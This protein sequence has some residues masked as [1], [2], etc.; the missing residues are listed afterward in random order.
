MQNAKNTFGK[1]KHINMTAVSHSSFLHYRVYN[2]LTCCEEKQY[3]FRN[4]VVTRKWPQLYT[5]LKVV[6]KRN[7]P[8]E[9]REDAIVDW[10]PDWKGIR[11]S[12]CGILPLQLLRYQRASTTVTIV[13]DSKMFCSISVL[14]LP[15]LLQN[16]TLTKTVFC[17]ETPYNLVQ[18]YQSLRGTWWLRL[19]KYA[20]LHGVASQKTVR[21]VATVIKTSSTNHYD[22]KLNGIGKAHR[23]IIELEHIKLKTGDAC[24]S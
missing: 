11:N 20:W 12:S 13:H 7:R 9:W 24:C 18:I 10:V 3:S 5:Y 19:S 2:S 21:F 23:T 8:P 14:L 4:K 16:F 1:C 15:V 22:P 6:L 17:N